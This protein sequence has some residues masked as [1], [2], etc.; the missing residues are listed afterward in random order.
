MLHLI[1]LKKKKM[2][3]LIQLVIRG[4]QITSLIIEYFGGWISTLSAFKISTLSN[5]LCHG[6]RRCLPSFVTR[7]RHY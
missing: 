3:H 2:L 7:E 5:E 1:F 6:T 4:C